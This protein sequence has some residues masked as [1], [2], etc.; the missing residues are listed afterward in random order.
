M[1]SATATA[2]AASAS[3][4]IRISAPVSR[5]YSTDSSAAT[6]TRKFRVF[7][8]LTIEPVSGGS[9]MLNSCSPSCWMLMYR[10]GS[11]LAAAA[12]SATS[13][14]RPELTRSCSVLA[15]VL[16]SRLTCDCAALICSRLSTNASGM[17]SSRTAVTATTRVET[18]RRRRM[19][20]CPGMAWAFL[21]RNQEAVSHPARSGSPR[22]APW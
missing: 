8:T 17:P 20:Q 18:S 6:V 16:A 22:R 7:A 9:P 15:T 13:A 4:P 19:A 21:G 11:D 14:G 5:P 12:A 3:P 1:A 2:T 10:S